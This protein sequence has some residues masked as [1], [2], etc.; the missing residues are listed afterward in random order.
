MAYTEASGTG[1]VCSTTGTLA[2]VGAVGGT[3]TTPG[4]DA[5]VTMP[6]NS[7]ALGLGGRE[8]V[9]GIL[10]DWRGRSCTEADVAG[11]AMEAVVY[12]A[13]V[14]GAVQGA[15]PAGPVAVP[16]ATAGPSGAT[17][18]ETDEEAKGPVAVLRSA[19]PGTGGDE[20]AEG[21]TRGR[22]W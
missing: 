2:N 1:D 19:S 9:P 20:G 3:A 21:V 6:G 7:V 22:V 18:A 12:G 17:P 4:T 15:M 10:I 5:N 13:P 11:R 14:A 8:A 16:K